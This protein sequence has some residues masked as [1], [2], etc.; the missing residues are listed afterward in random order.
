MWLNTDKLMYILNNV[1]KKG[2]SSKNK[3]ISEEKQLPTQIVVTADES[4]LYVFRADVCYDW[5]IT[6]D[7][8][9][10]D[11]DIYKDDHLNS[12]LSKNGKFTKYGVHPMIPSD[13]DTQTMHEYSKEIEEYN[14]RF[15]YVDGLHI[16]HTY[17]TIAHLWHIKK[18]INTT[19]WRFILDN[20]NSLITSFHRAFTGNR[21]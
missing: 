3:L 6:K 1:R 16:N 17:T 2:E 9:H 12:F 20:D 21:F 8:I 19:K 10:F 5:N 4:S 14:K 13:N 18:L 7:Q 15:V 11:T